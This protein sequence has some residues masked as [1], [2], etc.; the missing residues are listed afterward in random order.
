MG[1]ISTFLMLIILGVSQFAWSDQVEVKLRLSPTGQFEAKTNLIKGKVLVTNGQVT[2]QSIRVPLASLKT[3]IKL[4]DDH[5]KKKYLEIEKHPEA[6]LHMGEGK[7]GQGQG[8]LEIRG[9][10]RP[11]K[12]IYKVKE[13]FVEAEFPIRL[14]DYKISGI[15]Y[16]GVGVKDEALV[17]V[18]LA[19]SP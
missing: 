12:G 7:S 1:Q 2:A 11:I 4:R 18:K 9:I 3:G 6:I 5:M 19:V 17:K 14:S 8:E 16:M 13:G 15:R 10:K